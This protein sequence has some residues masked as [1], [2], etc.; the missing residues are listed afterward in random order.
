V[1]TRTR[2]RSGDG[3]G[4]FGLVP[5]RKVLRDGHEGTRPVE[6]LG[7]DEESLAFDQRDDLERGEDP[8]I[9]MTSLRPGRCASA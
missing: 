2:I 5:G 3:D 9:A 1:T 6:G 4:F 7:G 8:T